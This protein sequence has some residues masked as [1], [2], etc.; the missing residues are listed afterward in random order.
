[1]GGIIAGGDGNPLYLEY[2]LAVST[3]YRARLGGKAW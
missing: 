1:A 2:T 3:E